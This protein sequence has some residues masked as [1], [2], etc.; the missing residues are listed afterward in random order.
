MSVDDLTGSDG[1]VRFV[2]ASVVSTDFIFSYRHFWLTDVPPSWL[3][4]LKPRC[5]LGSRKSNFWWI[6]SDMF[7]R[8]VKALSTAYIIHRLKNS[9][10]LS[11]SVIYILDFKGWR[12]L[13]S[14]ETMQPRFTVIHKFATQHVTFKLILQL[15]H[16]F[17]VKATNILCFELFEDV[18]L[19][20][21]KSFHR[22]LCC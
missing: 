2:S 9:Y 17:Q 15:V 11:S 5:F 7:W 18:T 13:H 3:V 21:E 4:T 16:H 8:A 1:S 20:S 10:S 14:R 19:A 22:C 12:F 6:Q